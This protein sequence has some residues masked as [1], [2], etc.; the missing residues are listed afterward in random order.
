MTLIAMIP[1]RMGSQRLKKKNLAPLAGIPLI[2]RAVRRC[3][4]AGCF[5]RIIVNSENVEFR[6]HA[7]AEGAEFHERPDWL[8][9][10]DATSED[11]V[12]E[13]M[14]AH[15]SERLY[16]VHSIAPLASADHIRRFVEFAE[17]GELDT[18]LSCV[19]EQ[20]E[21]AI[22]GEPVNFTFDSKTN[23]Q[24]LRALQRITWSLTSWTPSIFLEAQDAG[25]CATYAGRVGIMPLDRWSGHVIKTQEDLDIAEALLSH[26][27]D[28][29]QFGG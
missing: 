24:D 20:I 29:P 5:D 11:F 22:A 4:A 15:P 8:G 3:Q 9:G 1:A 25:R 27:G 2:R 26:L 7:I 19:E 12:G 17:A 18:V 6:D 13:F 28:G 16:Q 23:S 21:C 10:H 14:R